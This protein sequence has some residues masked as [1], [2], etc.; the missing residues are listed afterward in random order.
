M[1]SM[2]HNMPPAHEAMSLH[3]EDLF[4]LVSDTTEG[5][6]VS[7]DE[8][9]S[10]LD[11]LLDDVKQAAKDAEATR[12]AEKEPHLEAGRQV[13]ANWKPIKD[14]LDMAATEIKKLLTPYRVAKQKAR[15]EAARRAR[16]EAEA[17]E[18]AARAKLQEP[19]H[20]QARFDAEEEFKQAT[21]LKAVANRTAREATGLRTYK[22]ASVTDHK[23]ALL[24][25]AKNDKAALDAFIE[26][27]ARRFAPTRAM[28]GV[29]VAD[30]KRAA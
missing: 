21:K 20:L 23:A 9:E 18:A 22:V 1:S 3:V 11:N 6:E 24:W 25:I 27:Y 12:K 16:E 29:D 30:E 17:K 28:D 15:D 10:A 13:D 4:K 7:T 26:D 5:A 2:G 19:E 8:Q 14:R